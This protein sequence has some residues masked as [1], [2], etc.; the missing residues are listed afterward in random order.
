MHRGKSEMTVSVSQIVDPPGPSL[1]QV[2]LEAAGE[3]QPNTPYVSFSHL[4]HSVFIE[5]STKSRCNRPLVVTDF[6]TVL[7]FSNLRQLP[8]GLIL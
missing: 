4:E 8:T 2:P 7:P 1:I 3:K 5:E 6:A